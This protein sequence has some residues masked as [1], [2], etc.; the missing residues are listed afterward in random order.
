MPLYGMSLFIENTYGKRVWEVIICEMKT[1]LRISEAN[2]WQIGYGQRHFAT[3]T[4]R[5]NGNKF[6]GNEMDAERIM[7]ARMS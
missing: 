1:S 3:D 4:R 2:L 5:K 6:E 7:A